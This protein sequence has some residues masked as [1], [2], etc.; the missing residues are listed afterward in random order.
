MEELTPRQIQ[1]LKSIVEEYTE[2]GNAVGSDVIE[3]KHDIGVSP[4]TIRNEMVVLTSAGYLRQPHTS[5]GRIPAPK[6]IKLY[7]NQLME[8]KELSV[9]EEVAAKEHMSQNKEDFDK[10]MKGATKAL[11]DSTHSLAIATT[12]KGDVWHAGYANIL[13]IPEFYNIDVTSRVLSL[14]EEARQLHE[15]FYE[16]ADWQGPIEVLFGEEL[17]WQNFEPVGIVAYQFNT[18]GGRGSLGIIG[19]ARFNYPAVVPVVRYFGDLV[20]EAAGGNE[21]E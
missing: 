18:P 4:A 14:L 15:I 5:A 3:K 21:K 8:E 9:A 6:A 11:A 12:E 16:H 1:I 13:D 7:V 10:L 19:P 20:Q 17:G 2:T